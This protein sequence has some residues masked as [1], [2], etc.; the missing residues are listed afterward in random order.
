MAFC[1]R[2]AGRKSPVATGAH[3]SFPSVPVFQSIAFKNVSTAPYLTLANHDHWT[4]E[5]QV[6]FII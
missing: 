5:L 3:P 4:G 1:F 2:K 6:S